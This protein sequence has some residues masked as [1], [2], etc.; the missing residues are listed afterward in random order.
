MKPD[1]EPNEPIQICAR[2]GSHSSD[3]I[4]LSD[5][6]HLCWHCFFELARQHQK[7]NK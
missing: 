1:I 4:T 7:H 3:G 2:C 6:E 5:G